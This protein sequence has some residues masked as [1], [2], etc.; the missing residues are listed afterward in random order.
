MVGFEK[1]E[2]KMYWVYGR[3]VAGFL[4]MRCGIGIDGLGEEGKIVTYEVTAVSFDLDWFGET[5][6]NVLETY[7]MT[8]STLS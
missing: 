4:M 8:S 2:G 3:L 6:S 1:G 5:S 7:D